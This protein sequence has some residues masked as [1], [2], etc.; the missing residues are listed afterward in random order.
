MEI[1]DQRT[2]PRLVDLESDVQGRAGNLTFDPYTVSVP[3]E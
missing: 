2:C 3:V 1:V